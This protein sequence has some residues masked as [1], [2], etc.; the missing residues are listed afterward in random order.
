MAKI[1][2]KLGFTYR[3]GDLNNNQYGRIDLDIH[4]IDTDLPLDEQLDKS[5][6][7]A[8]KIF[9]SVKTSNVTNVDGQIHKYKDNKIGFAGGGVPT[10]IKARGEISEE[11]F[12]VKLNK[13]I[14]VDIICTHA[15][16]LVD[17]L[18]IDVITNK[19]EQGW[20]SLN[21]FIRI[22]QPKL[23]LFGDVHQPKAT[24]WILGKTICMN[25]GY[26]RANNH[27][28]ELSSIDI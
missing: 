5:K 21:K 17:E 19:K 16:P 6:E 28:L 23:S 20:E 2:V 25:V 13:L 4:D 12:E 7:Y 14:D 8:D 18:I 27:Y 10:P 22:H 26:F 15:P 1:G 24:K 11:D 3:V 9:E